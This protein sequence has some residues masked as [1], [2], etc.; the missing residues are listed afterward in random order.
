MLKTTFALVAAL[1][2]VS[3]T[4]GCEEEKKAPETAPSATAAT[5]ASTA[6]TPP[7]APKP[8]PAEA[9]AKALKS[10]A[11]PYNAHD[12]VATGALYEPNGKVVQPGF[13]DTT[14]REA[15]V[16]D[17]QDTFSRYSDI[18][19]TPTRTFTHGSTAAIEW[20]FTGKHTASGQQVGF[21]GASV[22][23]YDDE[24]LIK[25]H[26]L[27]FDY[28][29]VTSQ[30]DPKAKAGTFRAVAAAPTAAPEN[31]VSKGTPDE[32]KTLDAARALYAAFEKKGGDVSP[33]FGDDSVSDDYTA[34]AAVKGLK[35]NKDMVDSFWKTFPDLAQTK[36]VQFAADGFVVTE[37]VLTGTQKGALGP[38]KP[39]NKP[40]SLHFVDIIQLKDGKVV[41]LETFGN[42]AEILVAIGAMPQPGAA[43][44][45]SGS[46]APS[47]APAASGKK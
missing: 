3:L 23:T 20:T 42:S 31:H 1:G 43:P 25:E 33:F 32:A 39:T 18:K 21:M 17:A 12:A 41:H 38:V 14:G 24:G 7:P 26:H 47:A 22:V 35:A 37:G 19:L 34:P 9:I 40:V 30:R 2:V 10:F 15:I 28:P 27:Y 13:P 11:A 8:T 36:P 44:A 5:S 4:C 46:A 45:T 16:K 6:A 29:T